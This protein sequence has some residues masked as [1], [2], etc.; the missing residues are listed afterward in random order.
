MMLHTGR[1]NPFIFL[2]LTTDSFATTLSIWL[3]CEYEPF[4]LFIVLKCSSHLRCG[5]LPQP[6]GQQGSLLRS[7]SYRR[8][9]SFSGTV[10]Q[11]ARLLQSQSNR[12]ATPSVEQTCRVRVRVTLRLTV[13]QSVWLGVEPHLGLMTRYLFLFESY[14]PVHMGRPLW[15][16]VGSVIVDSK[17]LSVYTNMYK[18][19]IIF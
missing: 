9:D 4:S 3:I 14:S 1:W 11:T 6:D 5:N 7:Q 19:T 13:S 10:I 16:E 18:F 12:Q 2:V 15:Q 17:S 8:P